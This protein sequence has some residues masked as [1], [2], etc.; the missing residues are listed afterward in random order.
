MIKPSETTRAEIGFIDLIIKGR[1]MY[2]KRSDV[3]LSIY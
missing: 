2:N 3:S 1:L